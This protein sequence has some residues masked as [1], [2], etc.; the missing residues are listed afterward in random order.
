MGRRNLTSSF[1]GLQCLLLAQ[2]RL[3]GAIAQCPLLEVERTFLTMSVRGP[4]QTFELRSAMS[5][6]GGKA[7]IEI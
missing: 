5:A 6:F 4:K 1:E 3:R 7:D 2:T